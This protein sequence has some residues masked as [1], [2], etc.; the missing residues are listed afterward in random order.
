MGTTAPSGRHSFQWKPFPISSSHFFQWKPFPFSGSHFLQQK[1][2]VLVKTAFFPFNGSH[3][4]QRKPLAF[5]GSNSFQWKLFLLTDDIFLHF[6]GSHSF[7]FFPQSLCFWCIPRSWNQSFQ[8]KPVVFTGS[9]VEAAPFNRNFFIQWKPF[10]S[11]LQHFHQ[12][13]LSEVT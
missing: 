10:L 1:L 12:Q 4:F 5:S 11:V 7:Q 8:K 3:F 13:K 6:S 9:M 2:Y